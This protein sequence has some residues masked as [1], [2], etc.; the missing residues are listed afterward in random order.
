MS[1]ERTGVALLHRLYGADMPAGCEPGSDRAGAF[2]RRGASVGTS[3]IDIQ[4]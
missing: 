3:G 1:P 4:T 2:G